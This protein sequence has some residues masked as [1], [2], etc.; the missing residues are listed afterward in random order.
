MAPSDPAMRP[1]LGLLT[2]AY[3]RGLRGVPAQPWARSAV[4]PIGT[5]LCQMVWGVVR[6]DVRREYQ[7]LG[8]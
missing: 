7:W 2:R 6:S 5:G 4:W 8:R 1:C 3:T